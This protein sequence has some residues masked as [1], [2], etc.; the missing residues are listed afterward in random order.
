MRTFFKSLRSFSLKD[1]EEPDDVI[2]RTPIP[3]LHW[4]RTYGLKSTEHSRIV[5]P[6]QGQGNFSVVFHADDFSESSH[7]GY[8]FYGLHLGQSDVLTFLATDARTMTGHF[9]DCRKDSPT[10]HTAC[11]LSFS[12]DPDKALVIDRGVAHIFD[13]LIGMVTLNQMRL[14]VDFANPDFNPATDVINVARDT[15]L[16]RFPAI[17][18]NRYK[19]PAWLCRIAVKAQ[20]LQLRSGMANPNHPFKFKVGKK[21]LTLTRVRGFKDAVR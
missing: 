12:G 7:G 16:D 19:A 8:E 20:R 1:I 18:V 6:S 4:I 11:A 15:P 13:N 10:L 17:S 9:V 14:Y 2:E 21:T 3:G 5:L